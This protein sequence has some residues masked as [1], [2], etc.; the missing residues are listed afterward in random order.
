VVAHAPSLLLLWGI[1]LWLYLP[2]LGYRFVWDDHL[3]IADSTVIRTPGWRGLWFLLTHGLGETR[4]SA[5]YRPLQSL[6]YWLDWHLWHLRPLGYHLVNLLWHGLDT[7]LVYALLHRWTHHQRASLAVALLYACHP[8]HTATVAYIA[9][10]ADLLMVA[11]LLG[12]ILAVLRGAGGVA[13][14]CFAGALGAKELAIV[15]LP[16]AIILNALIGSRRGQWRWL[17]PSLAVLALYA[18]IHAHAVL[19]PRGWD[20]AVASWRDLAWGLPWIMATDLRLMILPK[21]SQLLY[22]LPMAWGQATVPWLWGV[23][24]C[25]LAGTCAGWLW[26]R[27]PPARPP[28]AWLGMTLAAT[29]PL[30]VSV[31]TPV[32]EHWLVLPLIGLCWLVAVGFARWLRDESKGFLLGWL[33]LF[34]AVLILA[35]ITRSSIAVWQN[36]VTLYAHIT[37]WAP[38]KAKVFANYAEALS[39]AQQE[40]TAMEVAAQAIAL[41]PRDDTGWI[42]LGSG[43]LH[44][45][46]LPQAQW[47]AEEALARR[48]PFC[49]VA[50]QLLGYT[51][52]HRAQLR[53]AEAAFLQAVQLDETN[54]DAWTYLGGIYGDEGRWP[55]ALQAWET[56][57]RLRPDLPTPYLQAAIAERALGHPER[58]LAYKRT[59][60]RLVQHLKRR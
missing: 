57:V 20:T 39:E 3:F 52:W 36:D 21:P 47:A 12:M 41:D 48:G 59:A 11:G 7:T 34:P 54:V 45:Q 9:G 29:W 33:L 56:A 46:N 32:S 18:L 38:P 43:S 42:Q 35:T 26:R 53:E 13:A 49:T 1:I 4:L 58:A 16:L 31:T 10:R 55:E 50:Y 40:A 30:Y 19:A 17:I 24:L 23:G 6:T 22:P 8:I 25:G 5:Y 28:I 14:L 15:G 2:T 60:E 51:Y 37:R 44:Q 27:H